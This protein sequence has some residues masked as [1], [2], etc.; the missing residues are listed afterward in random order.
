MTFEI[1]LAH[2]VQTRKQAQEIAALLEAMV[3]DSS[4]Q[5]IVRKTEE[6]A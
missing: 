6:E 5:F 3:S 4:I 1:V 2:P